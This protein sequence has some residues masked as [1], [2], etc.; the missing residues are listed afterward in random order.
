MEQKTKFNVTL[1]SDTTF[2]YL[3]KNA[4]YAKWIYEI[5]INRTGINLFEYTMIDNEVNSGSNYIKD[6]RMD[7]VFKKDNH[8]VIIELQNEYSEGSLIKAYQYLY[9]I[10]G[11]SY[12][13]G[14]NYT[15]EKTTLIMLNNF[16][17]KEGNKD[18]KLINYNLRDINNL[19]IREDIESYEIILPNY[20]KKDYN[21]CDEIEKRL[22][23]FSCKSIDEMNHVVDNDEDKAIVMELE[24][25]SM[26]ENFRY[27]YDNEI[28]QKKLINS[29]KDEGFEQGIEKGIEQGKIDK[30]CEIVNNLLKKDF[31]LEEIS[32][33]INISI[34]EINKCL[35]KED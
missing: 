16:L 31:S 35:N 1:V 26:D 32:E 14:S 10:A 34:E 18:I 25:L 15:K 3:F 22:W 6:Y 5:I 8:T 4:Q 11:S 28:V 20:H 9:R 30:T 24:R 2:K 7:L 19:F 23:L 27:L 33:M 12:V 13:V 17:P 21:K 29:A